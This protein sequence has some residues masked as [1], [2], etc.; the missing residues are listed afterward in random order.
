MKT[1]LLGLVLLFVIL[2]TSLQAEYLSDLLWQFRQR[3]NEPDTSTS[4]IDDTTAMLFID[5]AQATVVPFGGFLPQRVDV[6]YSLDSQKYALPTD[7][8]RIKFVQF[9]NELAWENVWHNPGKLLGDSTTNHFWIAWEHPEQ[10]E[11]YLGGE[12]W[13]PGVQVRCHY[14]G[15][16]PRLIERTDS[17]Y[18]PV[19]LHGFI[20]TEAISLYEAM[21]RNQQGFIL[22]NNVVRQDMG[23]DLKTPQR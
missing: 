2:S 19:D 12:Y 8:K 3:I 5:K 1:R 13:F 9:W 20:L 6:T 14:L 23:I 10:A 16:A 11:I 15:I 21:K 4:L 22:F 18:V 17:V 7:F